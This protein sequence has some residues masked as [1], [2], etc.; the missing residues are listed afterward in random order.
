M[1]FDKLFA[2]KEYS[3]EF[4]KFHKDFPREHI[5]EKEFLNV[6]GTQ[7]CQ[8][9]L[10]R[11]ELGRNYAEL[12]HEKRNRHDKNAMLVMCDN[13]K[14]GYVPKTVSEKYRRYVEYDLIDYVFAEISEEKKKRFDDNDRPITEMIRSASIR[15]KFKKYK[16]G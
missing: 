16:E 7:Y 3:D 13:R 15:I 8:G 5:P 1:F 2:T 4:M 10:A 14:I 9:N 6:N 12:K 11:V